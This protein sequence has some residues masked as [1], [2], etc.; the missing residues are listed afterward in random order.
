MSVKA[1]MKV[2]KVRLISRI[3]FQY[4]SQQAPNDVSKGFRGLTDLYLNNH[5]K[6]RKGAKEGSL[7]LKK[8]NVNLASKAE[9]EERKE[10]GS[11]KAE[12]KRKSSAPTLTLF[13]DSPAWQASQSTWGFDHAALL[14]AIIV[15]VFRGL[16]FA[17]YY[18][19]YGFLASFVSGVLC[20]TAALHRQ[21]SRIRGFATSLLTSNSMACSVILPRESLSFDTAR[22]RLLW[23]E[24]P[25]DHGQFRPRYVR[26]DRDGRHAGG[27]RNTP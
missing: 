7:P 17:V 12:R 8:L 15:I 5:A 10:V 18:C 23:V 2:A 19:N 20:T 16:P 25:P 14:S 1:D 3:I 22:I 13:G 26:T 4:V 11:R 21:V 27:T 9:L 6:G 24:L